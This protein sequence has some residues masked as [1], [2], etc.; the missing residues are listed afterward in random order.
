[1]TECNI[2]KEEWRSRLV[3]CLTGKALTLYRA[4]TRG[5]S[6]EET[7]DDL[8]EKLLIA[9]G[10][11]L[12]QTR[13][14]FWQP[15][16]KNLESPTETI[17]TLSIYLKR[18]TKDCNDVELFREEILLGRLMT[19]YSM[20]LADEVYKSKPSTPSRQQIFSRATWTAILGGRKTSTNARR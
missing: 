15:P 11:G 10:H 13:Q 14:K 1:M 9:M 16:Q 4:R 8:K 12:Q 2:P 19:F 5:S 17:R 18:I 20:D 6:T 3:A 7:F